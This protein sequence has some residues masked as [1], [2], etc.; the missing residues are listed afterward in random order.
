M[1]GSVFGGCCGLGDMETWQDG[2]DSKMWVM[3]YDRQLWQAAKLD[4]QNPF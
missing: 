4:Y 3:N 2:P 1:A